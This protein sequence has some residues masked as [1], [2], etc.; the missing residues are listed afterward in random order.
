MTHHPRLMSPLQLRHVTL[1]NRVV[2]GAHTNNMAEDGLPGARSIGYLRERALGGAGMV[3]CEP[4]PVHRTGGIA[5]LET[6]G[7]L[8]AHG[9]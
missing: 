7:G 9:N 5:R 2:F 8:R 1:R 4:V 6:P 3:V